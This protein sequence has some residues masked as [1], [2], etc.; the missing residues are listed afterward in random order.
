MVC[1]GAE[2]AS[3]WALRMQCYQNSRVLLYIW[4]Q[5]SA[6]P[7]MVM[8]S[9]TYYNKRSSFN[10]IRNTLLDTHKVTRCVHHLLLLFACFMSNTFP[11]SASCLLGIDRTTL[12]RAGATP[13]MVTWTDIAFHGT[14]KIPRPVLCR[15][16]RTKTHFDSSHTAYVAI[17]A[18]SRV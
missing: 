17:L 9:S 3:L 16:R 6:V 15:H 11:V 12:L 13:I 10:T 8:E 18:A 4:V 14:Q 7:K 5:F 2:D 1:D